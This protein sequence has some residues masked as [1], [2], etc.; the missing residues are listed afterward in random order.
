MDPSSFLFQFAILSCLLQEILEVVIEV[1]IALK[2]GGIE[3][4]TIAYWVPLFT[5]YWCC[6]VWCQDAGFI[7][8]IVSVEA[9]ICIGHLCLL[10]LAIFVCVFWFFFI[11]LLLGCASV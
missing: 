8:I 3:A 4:L 1:E 5:K 9:P 6:L 7:I 10:S 2:F 11:A